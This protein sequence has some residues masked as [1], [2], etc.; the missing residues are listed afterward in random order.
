MPKR[1]PAVPLAEMLSETFTRADGSSIPYHEALPEENADLVV[2]ILF[3]EGEGAKSRGCQYWEST[4]LIRFYDL[5]NSEGK[6]FEIVTNTRGRDEEFDQSRIHEL[7]NLKVHG[8]GDVAEGEQTRPVPW[9][10][11]PVEA[12]K[13]SGNHK[14]NY[15][16]FQP[17]PFPELHIFARGGQHI[18]SILRGVS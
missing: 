3:T 18:E 7:L 11:M 16:K 5:V 8:E 1:D 2:A 13:Y 4:Q 15:D 10:L 9:L 14:I 12:G 17:V 6:K